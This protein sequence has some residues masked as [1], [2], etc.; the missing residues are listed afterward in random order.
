MKNIIKSNKEYKQDIF[1]DVNNFSKEQQIDIMEYAKSVCEEWWVDEL[2]CSRS[3]ARK[4][5]EMDW[6]K[7]IDYFRDA[8][9]FCVFVIIQRRFLEPNYLEIGY[10]LVDKSRDLFLWINVFDNIEDVISRFDLKE[11]RCGKE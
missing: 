10:R 5:I 9:S 4:K 2:D 6:E 11:V 1:Y 3:L 7:A 8:K